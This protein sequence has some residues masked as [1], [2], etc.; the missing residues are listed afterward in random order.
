MRLKY[1]L[2][3]ILLAASTILISLMFVISS[4]SFSRGFLGYIN[5]AE[6]QQLRPLLDNII[7]RY[8]RSNGW[9]WAKG[10]TREWRRLLADY[11][12]VRRGQEQ[13][14]ADSQ[15]SIPDNVETDNLDGRSFSNRIRQSRRESRE[16]ARHLAQNAPSPPRKRGERVRRTR[17]TPVHLLADSKKRVIAGST[18]SLD[19]VA[20]L[21][22][23]SKDQVVGY[24]GV[25][26]IARLN[27]SLD[28]AFEFQQRN[29][30]AWGALAM[31]LLSAIL[32]IPLASWLVK[33]LLTLNGAISEVSH[34]NYSHRVELKRK[35]EIADLAVGINTLASTLEVNRDT[36]R[37]WVAEISHELRTP[38]AVLQG[39]LEAM[40]DGV[41][42]MDS[43]AVDSIHTEVCKLTQLIDDLHQLSLSDVGALEYRMAPLCL[44]DLLESQIQC[45]EALLGDAQ[46]TLSLEV[47][48]KPYLISGDEQRL[49]Q[50]I[51]NLLQNSVRYT[52][53]PGAVRVALS[54]GSGRVRLIWED[55]SPGVAKDEL[56][57]LFEPL[58]RAE[59][60]RSREFGGAGLGLSIATRIVQAHEGSI[61]ASLSSLGGL[62]LTIDFPATVKA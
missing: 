12:R 32:S 42:K 37:R 2:F 51:S 19:N 28:Q 4:W 29:S 49:G 38:V 31:V 53:T 46:L 61:E 41:R 58:F 30:F 18:K 47:S 24:L 27:T 21:S 16:S 55:S 22:L 62:K 20:W 39:E 26:K 11:A 8:E 1:Q 57:R 14:G 43:D 23:V 34:G 40:Q 56:T 50:L 44:G 25:R 17:A 15:E 33:P 54:A 13:K 59:Q 3:L 52:N 35:D 36:R 10:N 45:A 48:G 9:D 7:E 6:Q 60:S 5:S